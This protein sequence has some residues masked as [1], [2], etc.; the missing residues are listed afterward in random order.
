V[1][2]L[3]DGLSLLA[4]PIA[5]EAALDTLAGR[6]P[7][8]LAA[9]LARSAGPAGVSWVEVLTGRYTLDKAPRYESSGPGSG[10]GT[11]AT[12]GARGPG[13]DPLRGSDRREP[14]EGVDPRPARGD[15]PPVAV[16]SSPPPRP[17][18]TLAELADRLTNIERRLAGIEA[19]LG[20]L[21]PGS[22]PP[23]APAPPPP[24][25]PSSAPPSAGRGS[26]PASTSG[27][28]QPR[29]QSAPPPASSRAH[30]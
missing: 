23:V 2:Q 19:A 24:P 10:P 8:P 15:Q 29:P 11:G 25:P 6:T 9:R 17:A 26:G 4:S 14:R 21:R 22:P 27:P 5:V 16:P 7:T 1:W 3:V 12:S 18:P 28:G 30:R 13:R 20:A